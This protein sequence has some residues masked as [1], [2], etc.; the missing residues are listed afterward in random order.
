[1]GKS[2]SIAIFKPYV[3]APNMSDNPPT[4]LGPQ[5][6]PR[7]KTKVNDRAKEVARNLGA[8][9]SWVRAKNVGVVMEQKNPSIMPNMIITGRE[10]P[11]EKMKS[12]FATVGK[13]RKYF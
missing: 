4:K 3:P 10:T 13:V 5:A 12:N 6:P 11:M 8:T 7:A 9:T 2:D 1:M